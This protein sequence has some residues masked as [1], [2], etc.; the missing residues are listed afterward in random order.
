MMSATINKPSRIKSASVINGAIVHLNKGQPVTDS[1]AISREFGRRHDNVLKSLDELIACGTIGRLEIKESYYLNEQNKRQR[2]IE[3]TE[4]GA[5]IAMPFI[6]GKN[7]R[8]GQV[9]LVDAF[10]RMRDDQ[11]SQAAG[12]WTGS[13]RKV[14]AGY[15]LMTDA[16]QEVRA[17]DGKA[18]KPHHYA[19]EAKLI[20]WLLFGRFDGADRDQMTHAELVLLDK[21]E[22]KNAIWI[23]RGRTY[24][25]RKATLPA[26]LVSLRAR[27]LTASEKKVLA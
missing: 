3:L 27:A 22:A 13:R 1:L 7:S 25:E 20:N 15:Q 12:D 16:L 17:D 11:I 9:R 26:Y 2:L 14:S 18:T 10:L 23:A 19:N 5:L 24:D 4:R 6:G 21:V 8:A